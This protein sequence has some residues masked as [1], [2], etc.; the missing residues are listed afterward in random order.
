M[1]KFNNLKNKYIVWRHGE[2]EA[3]K[4]QIIVSGLENGIYNYGLTEFGKQQVSLNAH[5][6]K[7][8][9]SS[10]IVYSSPFKRCR[11][12]SS[13]IA[14][15]FKIPHT[16]HI[17]YDLRERY[18]GNLDGLHEM[19]YKLVYESDIYTNLKISY[20]NES[21]LSVQDRLIS[22]ICRIENIYSNKT[23][24]LVT[25]ADVGE[26]LQATFEGLS[27]YLHRDLPK[28]RNAEAR[29]LLLKY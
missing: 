3:N 21:V 2:S 19:Y 20:G 18:F 10:V 24:I 25:H 6:V 12:T 29:I 13:I 27:P 15:E 28:L 4:Q 9:T 8:H 16:I 11:E 26:I 22:L 1:Y 14:H 17:D 23:I 5:K 7:L